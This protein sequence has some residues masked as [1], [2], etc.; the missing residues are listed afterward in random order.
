[1]N[2]RTYGSLR[3][4][5]GY[6]RLEAEPHL[7][8][9]A[10]RL[11]PRIEKSGGRAIT[12]RSNPE[13][14]RDLEWFADRYPL[15]I[16]D[17]RLLV[18]EA[19]R[20]RE[21]IAR[22][23]ELIDP[24]YKPGAVALS[25][26]LRDYQRR[27][28]EVYLASGSLLLADDVGLGKTAVGIGS[29]ADPRT[30]PAVVA[31]LTFLP[32]QWER[33]IARFAPNL[34]VHVVKKMEPYDLK[35]MGRGPDV[36]VLNY[37]KLAP[38]S[39]VLAGY[40]KSIV[41][42]EIQELRSGHG[43]AKYGAA[44]EIARAASFRLGLSA[45][46]IYNYGGEI[47]NVL[48]ILREDGLGDRE[49]FVREWCECSYGSKPRIGDP[50]AL[51]CYLRDNF[52]ML[53]RTR[54]NV[55]R[56]LP[57]LSRVQ[58]SIGSD[59]RELHKIKTTAA[60]LARIIL[61][62][63]QSDKG[64]RWRAG[65]EF[66]MLMRQATGLAKAPYVA[67]F[68]RLLVESGESVLLF[69]W[70]RGVYEIWK[71]K[72]RDLNPVLFTGSESAAEKEESRAAFV[73]GQSKLMCMSLRSGA[74]LDGLQEVCRV[75]VFGELDWSPG[76][77]DQCIG[78]L[79]RDGQKDP[80]TAY[81]LVAEDGSDPVIADVLGIKREQSEGIRNPDAPLIE[82]YEVAE[83]NLRLLAERYLAGGIA[84]GHRSSE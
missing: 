45:T 37:H 65:G 4:E 6:W 50:T 56:E 51:G 63:V 31:T 26:P 83:G 40:A 58:H 73:S 3:F 1:M 15:D 42:D 79:H 77:H 13:V 14:C 36:V 84:P 72:L 71:D 64:E 38:W 60:D 74:G 2:A 75:V 68:V 78:R 19:N 39:G 67:D 5:D 44:E 41:F 8:I 59:E 81:F 25:I 18:T 61:G 33:E 62:R 10:K 12:I 16:E 47:W 28:V 7:I 52:L 70:H 20:F 23:E 27:A 69:G 24:K 48:N 32:R 29:F 53:R 80:V 54:R 35:F 55:G 21:N 9:K 17:R 82:K 43:A 11:F 49:E 34:L 22:L 57:S 76:V 66:D 30:L 46:P